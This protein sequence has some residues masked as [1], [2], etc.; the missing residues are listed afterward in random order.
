[1]KISRS[2]SYHSIEDKV[3]VHNA[4]NQKDYV[5]NE[6]AGEVLNYVAANP[7]VSAPKLLNFFAVQSVRQDV[8]EF[9][10]EMLGEEI[11]TEIE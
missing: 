1:M 9:V 10:D 8:G 11:L 5:L 3:Y 7:G 4:A 6:I 2:I